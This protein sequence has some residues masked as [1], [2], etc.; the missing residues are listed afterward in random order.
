MPQLSPYAIVLLFLFGGVGFILVTLLVGR[1]LRPNRPNEEKMT[2]YES[3]EDTVGSAWGNFNV[4]FYIIALIFLLFELELVFLFPW[5]IVFGDKGLNEETNG[6]WGQFAVI[7]TF[8]FVGLLAVG[9]AYAWRR[10]MLEWVK[11]QA[12][13]SRYGTKVPRQLYDAVNKKYE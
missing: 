6:L 9:L 8:V 13:P 11:P 3:G 10:G 12:K 7:E 4:R 5:A 1:I 2:T